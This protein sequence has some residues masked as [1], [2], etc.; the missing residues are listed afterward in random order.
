LLPLAARGESAPSAQELSNQLN[1]VA[2]QVKN[3]SDSLQVVETQYADRTEPSADELA[4]R[5]YS[6]GEIQYL[7]GDWRA[8]SVLF[9]DLVSDKAFEQSPHRPDALFYLGDALYQQGN[10]IG[11]RLY[12][13]QLLTQGGA[14]TR[15]A[16]QRYLEIASKLNDFEGIDDYIAKARGENGTLPEDIRYVYAKWMFHRADLAPA[17][18]LSRTREA[19]APLA[20]D[21]NS[22]YRLQAQYFLAVAEVQQGH[23]AEAVQQ[24]GEVAKSPSTNERDV[25][26][27]EMANLSL[28][29]LLYELGK[30]DEAIDRYQEIPQGSDSFPDSLYE[31]AW[32]KEKKGD[33]DGAKNAVELLSLVAPDST[34]KPESDILYAHLFLKLRKY[35]EAKDTYHDVRASFAPVRDQMDTL[36][37]VNTDPIA[38]FDNLLARND[39]N[40]DVNTLL[41]PV[42][43]KWAN[44]QREVADATRMVGD[45]AAGRQGLSDSKDIVNSILKALGDQGLR[46]FPALQEGYARADAVESALAQSQATLTGVEAQL[47]ASVQT[48]DERKELDGLRATTLALQRKFASL[49]KSEK[50]LEQ[51]KERIQSRVDDID[52]KAFQLDYEMQSMQAMVTAILKWVDDTRGERHNTPEDERAFTERVRRESEGLLSLNHELSQLR[53][54][55]RQER[56]QATSS[57]GG[58]DTVRGQLLNALAREHEL[59]SHTEARLPANA[60]AVIERAHQQRAEVEALA[61]RID[62]AKSKIQA[63][64]AARRDEIRQKL[65]QE[66]ALLDTYGGESTQVSTDARQLV[67][68]IAF[69]SFRRVRQ[70]FYELVLKADVGMIDVAFNKK[71]DQTSQI[72]KVSQEKDHELRALDAEFKDV[73]K[74]VD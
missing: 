56:A 13:R 3:A 23:L 41:P 50:E 36:L 12:L 53:S 20:G 65:A 27:K 15:Q 66:E 1:Q 22:P 10:F 26:V 17:E 62:V 61:A 67:G 7:L 14:H 38:Y 39:K 5:R 54:D 29:R 58:D 4:T 34:L 24:L 31:I 71:Q 55:L 8:C 70:Q 21:P 45:L 49:P 40:L 2:V 57:L 9:Y 63:Q 6:D 18:R 69:E 64:V 43:V 52:R 44:T 35:Q 73:L 47:V 59:I 60:Q 42:A 28:G 46:A 30:Y 16:L 72:Q 25:K 32:A 37:S 33:F 68:K 51:R 19:F 11:A 74:D 48:P